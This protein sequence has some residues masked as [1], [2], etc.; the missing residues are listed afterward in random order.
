MMLAGSGM[1][2]LSFAPLDQWYLAYVALAVW[3]LGFM[4]CRHRKW[5]MLWAYLSAVGFWAA[6]VYWL[7]WITIEGYLALI[8]YL[9][10]YGLLVAWLLRK[11]RSAGW[12]AWLALPVLWVAAEYARGIIISGFPW[13]TLAHSQYANIRL[14]QIADATGQYGV[15]FFVAMVNG[16]VL[17][18]ALWVLKR[19]Q[20]PNL[21][22]A[23]N[24]E[25]GKKGICS[26]FV[27]AT[28]T[29]VAT[30]G[31]LLYGTFRLGE[32]TKRPGPTMGLVQEAFPNSIFY[33]GNS[34]PEV[35]EAYLERTKELVGQKLDKVVW[36]ESMLGFYYL[37]PD[38][39]RQLDPDRK[40]A[41]GQYALPDDIRQ[42]IRQRQTVLNRLEALVRELGCPILAGGAMPATPAGQKEGLHRN[43]AILYTLKSD[44][45]GKPAWPDG[46]LTIAGQ[47]S[48]T[49]LVP[50]GEYVPFGP[51]E[52][53]QIIWLH[54]WLRSFIPESMPQLEMGD[55]P[56]MKAIME[57][58]A[59]PAQGVAANG[60]ATAPGPETH[61]QDA[62]AT[63]KFAV[64]LCYE[65]VFD[66][67]CRGLVTPDGTK[68]ADL[69]VN[70]SNDGWFI[71]VH[72][73]LSL[74]A[75]TELD[76]HLVQY[77]FRAIE[78]RVPVVRAVN[79]GISGYIDSEG[80]I[81]NV[82]QEDGRRRMVTGTL[83]VQTAIDSRR[84]LYSLTGDA[85]AWLA[86][87]AALAG[88]AAPAWKKLLGRKKETRA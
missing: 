76:Q 87:A 49:H 79:V 56:G 60:A 14:I 5:A 8:F 26:L 41:A 32:D 19:G 40:N 28:V 39:W 30:A 58:S 64:P 73:D 29:A 27:G 6:G 46:K 20:I 68:R 23:E 51:T 15:S 37:D 43:S 74:T 78:N 31:L 38:F 2:L 33:H 21:P 85:F 65:G 12:P 77:V 63:Y 1:L 25:T 48:K 24:K 86:C 75:S 57:I 4:A 66:R 47:S 61:G 69:L 17:E 70:I 80:R 7:T 54:R 82:I 55:G 22:A 50:F 13:F 71:H 53:L 11:Y 44:S 10:V 84:S 59:R 35:F 9:G 3:A 88:L 67:Y 72:E 62:R 83:V 36:P 52:D 18:V 16:L 81:A 45:A 34:G 42:E